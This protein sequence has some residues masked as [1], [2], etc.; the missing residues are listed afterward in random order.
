MLLHVGGTSHYK[1]T[2]TG[3]L[4]SLEETPENAKRY[5]N[6]DLRIWPNYNTVNTGGLLAAAPSG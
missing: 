1:N 3:G 5:T 2:S 4:G 6:W